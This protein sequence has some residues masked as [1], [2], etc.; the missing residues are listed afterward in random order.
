MINKI[1]KEKIVSDIINTMDYNIPLDRML[2]F[3]HKINK[4]VLTI[5][6]SSKY[7]YSLSKMDFPLKIT[8]DIK[9]KT[10]RINKKDIDITNDERLL[11][12]LEKCQSFLEKREVKKNEIIEK[13][14]KSSEKIKKMIKNGEADKYLVHEDNNGEGFV[15]RSY[16]FPSENNESGLVI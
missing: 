15:L 4:G 2:G 8:Y 10:V 6:L 9:E 14:R 16:L 5:S 12:H 7:N 11:K 13:Q 1:E 3:L